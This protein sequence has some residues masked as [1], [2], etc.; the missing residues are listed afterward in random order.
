MPEITPSSVSATKA[1]LA[2]LIALGGA[3]T[4]GL[5][6]NTLTIA[7]AVSAGTTALIALGVVYGVPNT[8]TK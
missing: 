1:I 2:F 7:E 4:V 5:V 6:D 3:L 8:P